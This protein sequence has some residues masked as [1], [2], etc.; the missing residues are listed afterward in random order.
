MVKPGSTDQ[1]FS[2]IEMISG[3]DVV[4]D[5]EKLIG[6]QME[7]TSFSVTTGFSK[8]I[9]DATKVLLVTNA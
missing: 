1:L 7:D 2:L 6:T 3:S 8:I 5:F 9:S 4:V